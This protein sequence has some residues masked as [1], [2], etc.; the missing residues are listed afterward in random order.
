MLAAGTA[1]EAKWRRAESRH[2]IV[3]GERSEGGLADYARRLEEFDGVLRTFHG[4]PI[5]EDVPAKLAVYLV[6]SEDELRRIAPG[7][8]QVGG[9]YSADT[10]DTYAVALADRGWGDLALLHEYVH[11]FM[12][13]Y[14]A[15]SYPGWMVEGY[16][17]YFMTAQFE[18]RRTL[19]GMPDKDRGRVLV[20]MGPLP[21][22][23]L[24]SKPRSDFRNSLDVHRYYATSWLLTHYLMSDPER[25]RQLADYL[26]RLARSEAPLAAWK[27]ATGEAATETTRKLRGYLNSSIT[28]YTLPRDAAAQRA[29]PVTV[30]ELP[31]SAGEVLLY[32]HG[33]K[34]DIPETEIPR[35][36]ERLRKAAARYPNDRLAQLALGRIE[37]RYGDR[38]KGEAILQKLLDANPQDEEVL[39]TLA[40]GKLD[41]AAKKGADRRALYAEAQT[42]LGKAFKIDPEDYRT[43]YGFAVARSTEPNFPSENVIN[44]LSKAVDL[45]PQVPTVRMMAA[46][47]MMQRDLYREAAFTLAPVAFSPHGGEFAEKAQALL[48]E[49]EAKAGS[50]ATKSATGSVDATTASTPT[51]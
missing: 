5:D 50:A 33:V 14:Y 34:T 46:E 2:F 37:V 12:L 11:H 23:R 36:F 17:E 15:R 39:Q 40:F 31:D 7:M 51:S 20:E 42:L 35:Y 32:D 43:L 29:I 38:A 6:G 45:A 25:K 41:A 18:G 3:Y 10:T 28:A 30:T 47:A 4:R 26:R 24:L 22:E 19:V 9:F 44:V 16:A 13:H 1:A 48:K 49:I 8:R 21:I 27:A